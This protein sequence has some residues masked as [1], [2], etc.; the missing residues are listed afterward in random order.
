MAA[1]IKPVVSCV[2]ERIMVNLPY[3][4][5]VEIPFKLNTQPDRKV[6]IFVSTSQKKMCLMKRNKRK[7]NVTYYT[8]KIKSYGQ[9]VSQLLMDLEIFL[10]VKYQC[11][12]N[13]NHEKI[14]IPIV[15]S[16]NEP[17]RQVHDDP[18]V[19][20]NATQMHV[21]TENINQPNINNQNLNIKN[22]IVCNITSNATVPIKSP[23]MLQLTSPRRPRQQHTTQVISL[24]F[25]RC[26]SKIHSSRTIY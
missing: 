20:F 9:E 22:F 23:S 2:P 11:V 17:V 6:D 10:I 3:S 14:L 15:F 16:M 12:S 4:E 7:I 21:G 24:I 19:Q 5:D 1:N 13:G 8:L 25:G 26:K 18:Q